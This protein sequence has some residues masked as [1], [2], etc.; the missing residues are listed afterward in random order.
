ML[1][2]MT[3]WNVEACFQKVKKAARCECYHLWARLLCWTWFKRHDRFYFNKCLKNDLR[4]VSKGEIVDVEPIANAIYVSPV[5][6]I[7]Y[8]VK[9]I[10]EPFQYTDVFDEN[11]PWEMHVIQ[12][13]FAKVTFYFTRTAQT[14]KIIS[15]K[16]P[17]YYCC[18]NLLK[19]TFDVVL[20]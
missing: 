17:F 14:L 20:F 13:D 15:W 8:V 11:V 4:F 3:F 1:K 10:D 16:F 18:Q 7:R 5:D 2:L 9:H 6:F 19:S 12:C